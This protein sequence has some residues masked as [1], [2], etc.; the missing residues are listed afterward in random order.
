MAVCVC[1]SSGAADLLKGNASQHHNNPSF[2]WN[3]HRSLY[4]NKNSQYFKITVFNHSDAVTVYTFLFL[5]LFD[6]YF[7]YFS[8]LFYT[9]FDNTRSILNCVAFEIPI[10]F[11][12][13]TSFYYYTIKYLII[14]SHFHLLLQPLSNSICREES[15]GFKQTHI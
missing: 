9:H 14:S 2:N 12:I 1:A 4:T 7:C 11:I 8:F 10:I 3:S 15:P 5:F 6:F 13:S